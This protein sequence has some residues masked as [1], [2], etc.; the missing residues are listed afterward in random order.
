MDNKPQKHM[1]EDLKKR[2]LKAHD[3]EQLPTPTLLWSAGITKKYI[4]LK[5]TPCLKFFRLTHTTLRCSIWAESFDELTERAGKYY[6]LSQNFTHYENKLIKQVERVQ[7]EDGSLPPGN[8]LLESGEGLRFDLIDEPE[9]FEERLCFSNTKDGVDFLAGSFED[10][11][12]TAERYYQ[13]ME[14][15]TVHQKRIKPLIEKA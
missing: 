5:Q 11:A 4:T 8:A 12:L 10:L 2:L 1:D 6:R 9:L 14:A 3:H 7:L 13:L 15:L